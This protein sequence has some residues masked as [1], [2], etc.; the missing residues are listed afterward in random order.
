MATKPHL[1]QIDAL[2]GIAALLVAFV[3]HQG[4]ILGAGRTGPLDGLPVFT[5]L[6]AYG[7]TLVDLFFVV[8]GF[9]FS[10]VYLEGGEL[11]G[12]TT[13]R[14]FFVS[15]FA[16]LYPLH[17]VTLLAAVVLIPY[18]T[19]SVRVQETYDLRHFVL[20]LLMLQEVGISEDV[21][22]NAPAWSISVEA[23]CYAVF[24][25]AARRGGRSLV[26]VA[27]AAVVFGLFLTVGGH[28]GVDHVSRGFVGFFAGHFAWRL[29]SVP[30]MSWTLVAII[31]A[32]ILVHPPKVSYGAWLGLT[33][34]PALVLLAL[35]SHVLIRP[36][37][38]WLG[39]ISYS[40]YLIHMPVYYAV[41]AFVFGGKLVPQP[42]WTP[43]IVCVSVATL[44]LAHLSY[45][46]LEA[47]ARR[48][49]KGRFGSK[50]GASA[51]F[52]VANRD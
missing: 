9:V 39:N 27:F 14:T 13:G 24:F 17:F 10:H 4:E 5:W 50:T 29:R 37:L 31:A 28:A 3:F 48:A 45:R 42:L 7:W 47:P 18:S 44:I 51:R 1:Q 36:I 38:R 49:I 30:C 40:I 41:S 46:H 16:R 34:W 23:L 19:V 26:T 2:R 25:F 43:V 6:H 8:S 22:F 12:K 52:V 33:A 35:R 15:R 21:S 11:R 20:N 32:G